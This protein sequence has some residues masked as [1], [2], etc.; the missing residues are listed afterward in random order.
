VANAANRAE[1]SREKARQ[2][3][4]RTPVRFIRDSAG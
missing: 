3:V 2:Y 4:V 1:R